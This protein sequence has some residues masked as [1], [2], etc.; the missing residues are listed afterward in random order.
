MAECKEMIDLNITDNTGCTPLHLACCGDAQMNQIEATIRTFVSAGID[1]NAKDT[2]GNTALH[3]AATLPN[4]YGSEYPPVLRTLLNLNCDVN[5]QNN[6]GATA[7]H[8]ALS[9]PLRKDHRNQNQKTSA[10]LLVNRGAKCDTVCNQGM[11]PFLLAAAGGYDD[12]L[13]KMLDVAKY[14]FELKSKIPKAILDKQYQPVKLPVSK[15]ASQTGY[16][17]G[18]S[19][20]HQRLRPYVGLTA[21]H[22]SVLRLKTEIIDKLVQSGA[23]VNQPSN[24]G[25]TALHL[26]CKA[27][28]QQQYNLGTGSKDE[29]LEILSF[30]IANG[31]DINI[32]E[33]SGKTPLHL[34]TEVGKIQ[35]FKHL[36]LQKPDVNIQDND[37]NTSLSVAITKGLKDMVELLLSNNADVNSSNKLNQTPLHLA[38]E[39]GKQEILTMLLTTSSDINAQDLN[40]QTPLHIAV[41][42]RDIAAV[43]QIMKARSNFSVD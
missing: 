23:S 9:E 40:G 7:L 4:P 30:L 24:T 13:I 15:Q 14:P 43:K 32:K 21:L 19:Q 2:N 36:L 17:Q 28:L 1:I 42:K 29:R 38:V 6:N 25:A 27:T 11:T 37:G 39:H 3:L 8:V 18:G 12:L 41:R 20:V 16:I 22:V 5:L 31:A 10:Y 35:L 26:A 33:T 34:L